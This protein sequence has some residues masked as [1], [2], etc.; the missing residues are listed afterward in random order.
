[1]MTYEEARDYI[2]AIPRFTAKNTKA[3]TVAF[4]EMLG[5][6]AAD[7]K[8][9]HVAGTNGKGSVCA[10]CASVFRE[11]GY[12]TAV[13]TS[14]H[15]VSV[16][17]RFV[18]DGE[19]ISHEDF[20]RIFQV[21]IDYVNQKKLPHPTF[22]EFLFFMAMLWFEEKEPDVIILETGLGGRLD[23]TNC[24]PDKALTVITQIGLDHMQYLG[25]TVTRIAM[26]KAGIMRPGVPCVFA[27]GNDESESVIKA[28]G[29][30]IDAPAYSVGLRAAAGLTFHKNFIDFCYH[31]RYY[32]Y[33]RVS[34]YTCAHYQVQNALLVLAGLDLLADVLPVSRKAIEKGLAG[35]KWEGRMEEVLPD[36]FLD[37]AHNEDGTEAFLASVRED[38]CE[39]RRILVYGAVSDKRFEESIRMIT[40]SGLFAHV[41]VTA[42]DNPRAASADALQALFSKE[43]PCDKCESSGQAFDSAL[44]MKQMNDRCYVAGSLYLVGEVKAHLGRRTG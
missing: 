2:F 12:K 23:A 24:V 4:Y 18:C 5:S 32:G 38:G 29:K 28:H 43:I 1:M 21:V 20:V 42:I 34:L 25:N 7:R 40:E 11:A 19:M 6:P 17:E 27:G 37:G 9:V 30:N 31:S 41:I 8:I 15:L 35:A 13:F 36:V 22:F 10:Y 3:D 14:P 44:S 39:G 26:E 16:R 33:V